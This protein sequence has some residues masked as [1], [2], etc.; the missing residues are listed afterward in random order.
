MQPIAEKPG[1]SARILGSDSNGATRVTFNGVAAKFVLVW[2]TE[3]TTT[4]P[5]AAKTGYVE[6]VTPRGALKSNKEFVVL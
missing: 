6:V 2:E 5:A 4:V 1:Q 3:I